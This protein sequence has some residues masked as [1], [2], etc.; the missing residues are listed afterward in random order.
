M[1]EPHFSSLSDDLPRTLR[2]ARDERDAREREANGHR[3]PSSLKAAMNA[4]S[5]NA[6]PASEYAAG[7]PLGDGTTVTRIDVP[8]HRLVA[9]FMKAVFA[10]LPAL[11]M[12]TI[13]LW[14]IGEVL[15]RYFPWLL[16][17]RI[18]IQFPG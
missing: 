10:A 7:T 13:M 12:L 8:F 16:K 18:L 6:M 1:P 4:A 15:Q 5:G 17:M 3:F 2:R 11:I 9:F 14:M